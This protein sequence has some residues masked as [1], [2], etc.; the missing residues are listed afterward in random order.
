[1]KPSRKYKHERNMTK[2]KPFQ[3][4]HVRLV[5]KHGS[6]KFRSVGIKGWRLQFVYDF[7]TTLVDIK[8][9]WNLLIFVTGFVAS[10]LVFALF[11]WLAGS[12]HG[13][14][15]EVTGD[16]SPCIINV[17]NFVAAYL[18]SIET[19]TTIGYGSRYVTEECSFTYLVVL[20]QSVIGAGLQTALVGL[21]IAKTKRA[22]RSGQWII[23]SNT[24]CIMKEDEQLKLVIR[25]GDTRNTPTIG[26]HVSG[27][28]FT[29]ASTHSGK[30]CPVQRFPLTFTSEGGHPFL[31]LSWPALAVHVINSKSPF[32][33]ISSEDLQNENFELVVYLEGT[34]ATTSMPFHAKTSYLPSDILW[35]YRF[36]PL[37]PL[38]NSDGRYEAD[39]QDFN[40][41]YP[42]KT[43]EFSACGIAELRKNNINLDQ[44]P[45]TSGQHSK[46]GDEISVSDITMISKAFDDS[47][48]IKF[49]LRSI[50]ST[51][52]Y[53]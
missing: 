15:G 30:S 2:V 41:T 46:D 25:V 37:L 28:V 32:W 49:R 16:W 18:F 42:V 23:F 5:T 29:K 45:G 7:F 27:L 1:M 47:S 17:N 3:S 50:S 24:A 8:W 26:A 48:D 6:S 52:H 35:G 20:L 31:F 40:L 14:Y 44:V 12:F 19:Q 9:R 13:D 36:D 34:I 38:L 53:M 21:V 51:Q 11:Y 33:N 22:K 39:F 43:P 10:W 4:S